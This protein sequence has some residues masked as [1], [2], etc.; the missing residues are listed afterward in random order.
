ML[1][2]LV[3][4]RNRFVRL[5]TGFDVVK[6]S[7]VHKTLIQY[8]EDSHAL[9]DCVEK[10]TNESKVNMAEI[11]D[12]ASNSIDILSSDRDNINVLRHKLWAV[13]D[14][15]EYSAVFNNV[16]PLI[17][18]RIA[19]YNRPKELVNVAIASVLKQTYQNFEI[20]VVS[21]GPNKD[22]ESALAHISDK[23]VRYVSLHNRGLYPEDP[24]NKWR[25]A[26][27]P[28]MNMGA[29]LSKG[30]WIAPLDDDDEFSEDHLEKLLKLALS[31]K[32]E[33][34]YGALIQ[35]NTVNGDEHVIWSSPPAVSQF[36]FQG[37]MY[38]KKIDFF[39]YDEQSWVVREPGD[40]NL[41]RRM[42]LAGVRISATKD[43]IGTMYATPYTHKLNDR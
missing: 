14:T 19:T 38:M 33:M 40:W 6:F 1:D 31:T 37:A 8:A 12:L 22:T 3:R 9:L 32:S 41:C 13:R 36:S 35:K 29:Y 2:K 28:G 20:I 26:G 16:E 25:V 21:D 23:R 7:E 10:L 17:S 15:K 39:E 42:Q 4:I 27:S 43:V 11:K 18:V 24:Q 5:L 30:E 34:V